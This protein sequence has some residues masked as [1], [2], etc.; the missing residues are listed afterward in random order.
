M[1]RDRTLLLVFLLLATQVSAMT[2]LS[3]YRWEKRI[4]TI[5]AESP[6]TPAY[7]LQAAAL[8]AEFTG[9]LE[10]DLIVLTTFSG[11]DFRITLIG[12]DGGP[13]LTR[14]EPVTAKELFEL[15]DAMPMRQAE[16]ARRET[17][18]D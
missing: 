8:M 5:E 9:L 18:G 1:Q 16:M 3:S 15:I 7:Q 14:K 17:K 10:R 12:K 4:V 2:D 13:K 6:A 11:S